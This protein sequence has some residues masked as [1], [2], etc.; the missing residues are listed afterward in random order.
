M[1]QLH[2]AQ[3]MLA[4]LLSIRLLDYE[5]LVS[6]LL[7]TFPTDPAN[8]ECISDIC[9]EVFTCWL[10]FARTPVANLSPCFKMEPSKMHLLT[11]FCW[12][13]AL[14]LSLYRLN[15]S[16]TVSLWVL[17]MG[18]AIPLST[19]AAPFCYNWFLETESRRLTLPV[20]A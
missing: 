20:S 12:H 13:T 8:L 3:R 18:P 4:H 14:L 1:G 6:S 5:S 19:T 11:H 17:Y 9:I 10:S 15:Y 16:L 7:S 2:V